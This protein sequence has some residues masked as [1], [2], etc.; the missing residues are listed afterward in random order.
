[1]SSYVIQL[2]FWTVTEPPR[3]ELFITS[4]YLLGVRANQSPLLHNNSLISFI[5]FTFS[6]KSVIAYDKILFISI[7]S[8]TYTQSYGNKKYT[9]F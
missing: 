5:Y 1:M 9:T 7:D 6:L 4:T 2:D 3:A 8:I